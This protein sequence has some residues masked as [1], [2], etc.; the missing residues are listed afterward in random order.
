MNQG[1]TKSKAKKHSLIKSALISCIWELILIITNI[2]FV[3]ERSVPSSILNYEPTVIRL[4]LYIFSAIGNLFFLIYYVYILSS[5]ETEDELAK[6]HRYKAGYISRLITIFLFSIILY[7]IK[8]FS[9]AY[10]NR[11]FLG[12]LSIPIIM[13]MTE[14]F[15]ENIVFI[16][17]EKFQL[18]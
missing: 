18:D 15:I 11:G 16:I 14:A 13:I 2:A 7:T 8:D 6:I 12:N 1:I 3:W 17:L 9:F 5:T 10:N 4:I